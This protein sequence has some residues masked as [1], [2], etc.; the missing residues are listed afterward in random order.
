MPHPAPKVAIIGAGP[1]GLT[2]ARLLHAS[3]TRVDLTIYELDASPT[4]RPEQGGTLDLHDKDGLAAIRKCG[5]WESFQRYARY[6]GEEMK[7]ADKNATVLVH[8]KPSKGAQGANDRPEIDRQRL[9]QI[10]LESIPE[11]YVRWG[12]HLREVEEDGQLRFDD[13]E[14]LEGPF[15]LVVGAD[16]AWSKVRAKLTDVKPVYSGVSGYEMEIPDPPRQCPHVDQQIGRGGWATIS[17]GMMLNG[18]RM[19]NNSLKVRSWF[20]C[21]E[22]EAKATLE[23][24]G[25]ERTLE[26]TLRRYD[27]WAPEVTEY[28]MQ[29]DIKS[30]KQWTLYELPLNSKWTHQKGFTLI[31]DAA[32]LATPFSGEGV[33][34]A[35]QDALEVAEWIEKSQA[36]ESDLTLDHAVSQF[37]QQSL[38]PRSQK[39]QEKTMFNKQ[40]VFGSPNALA[41]MTTIMKKMTSDSESRWVQMLGSAPVI[42]AVY[43][44]FWTRIQIGWAIRTYW[45]GT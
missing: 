37:E 24:F 13:R 35:M 44:F 12:M 40:T 25:P 9:K 29:G 41:V 20:S 5:L 36:S 11:K 27:G 42:A 33:N 21:P 30:L 28:L 43:G 31:G 1:A 6:E 4:A 38:F 45:R 17:D 2:L 34:K 18:Q 32:S 26:Q 15:D 39:L 10:L 7:I 3:E 23:K 16:G 14:K 8:K 22:G 19:G